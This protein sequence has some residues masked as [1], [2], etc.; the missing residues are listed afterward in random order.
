VHSLG[1]N[2]QK[3]NEF[4]IGDRV[5]AFHPMGTAG[6]A[7]AEYAVSPQH[8]VFKIP[9]GT[10]VEGLLCLRVILELMRRY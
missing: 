5:A 8:T 3:T 7:F 1:S 9:E 2:V 6:G 4:G 10:S